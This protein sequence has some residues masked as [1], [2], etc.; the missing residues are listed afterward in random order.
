LRLG[1][2]PLAI[3]T[4]IVKT[5][6]VSVEADGVLKLAAGVSLPAK[7]RLAVLAL[8]ADDPSGAQIAS[9]AESSGAFDFL[10]EEPDLYSDRDILPG[11]ENPRFRK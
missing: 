5:I 4:A 2:P 3:Y 7:T 11:R 8:D 10:R 1:N 6:E 9:L